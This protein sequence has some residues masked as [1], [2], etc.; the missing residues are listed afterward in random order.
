MASRIF[1]KVMPEA[2]WDPNLYL[3]FS[4]YRLRP[5]LELLQ[6]IPLQS[7]EITYDLGCGTGQVTRL[8]A[9]RW[10]MTT[11]YGLD[12]SREM[13]ARAAAEP[14][15]VRWLEADV[16]AWSP[17]E[18]PDLIFS[19]AM[20]HWVEGHHELFLHLIGL[21][22]PGGCLAVQMPLSW[23]LP[24]HRL[25]RETLADGGSGRKP[26]GAPMLRQSV[27]RKWVEKPEAY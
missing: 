16:R 4:D 26:L 20:L 24:S 15:K 13:L 12:S 25:M 18:P 9:E 22:K 23:D 6:R 7:P 19:N 11:V 5:A 8:I 2:G 21:L 10:P 3:K 14:G 17:E 27:A 1:Q